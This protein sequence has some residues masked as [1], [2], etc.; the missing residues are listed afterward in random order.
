M[1][2]PA[3]GQIGWVDLTVPGAESVRAFYERV[4]GWTSTPVG[5]GDHNDYCMHP[6]GG[7]APVAGICH[8]LGENA[9]LPP[10]WL[11]YITVTD[12]AESMRRC[13]AEGGKVRLPARRTPAGRYCVIEDPAGAVAALFEPANGVPQ[14][15]P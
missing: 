15:Q 4:A 11:I 10:Q 5:M 13:A 14:T 1:D 8:A 3:L 2:A 7:A 12:L 6:A 9:A